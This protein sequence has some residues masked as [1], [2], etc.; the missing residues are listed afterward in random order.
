MKPRK[1]KRVERIG[2]QIADPS[3]H[4]IQARLINAFAYMKVPGAFVFAVPNQSNR[5]INNAMKMK[6]EGVRSGVVDLVFLWPVD[7][8]GFLELKKPGGVLSNNQ[9]IFRNVCRTLKQRWGVAYSLDEAIEILR[10]WGAI[11]EGAVLL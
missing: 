11:R 8:V 1:R 4:L 9:L 2:G 10:G 3:E 5:H 6:S 7:E